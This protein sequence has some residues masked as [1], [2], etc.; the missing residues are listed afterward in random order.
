MKAAAASEAQNAAIV[1]RIPLSVLLISGLKT[2][3]KCESL[4]DGGGFDL[5]RKDPNLFATSTVVN[6]ITSADQHG[7]LQ[8]C[9]RGE[10]YKACRATSAEISGQREY[11]I[12]L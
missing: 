5:R 10:I 12:Q 1:L 2:K 8:K 11:C 9:I 7:L 3:T 6:M 4:S